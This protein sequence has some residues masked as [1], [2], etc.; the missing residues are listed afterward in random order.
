MRSR[1][2]VIKP[3][4]PLINQLAIKPLHELYCLSIFEQHQLNPVVLFEALHAQQL[5]QLKKSL[6]FQLYL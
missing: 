1:A 3:M 2:D 5:L 6:V 4:L